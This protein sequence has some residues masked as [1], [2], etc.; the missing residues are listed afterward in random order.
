MIGKCT[1]EKNEIR[2]SKSTYTF[3]IF[4]L[5]Q[6]LNKIKLEKIN[7]I[8]N[9][10]GV[11][12]HKK[13]EVR[14]LTEDEKVILI[15]EFKYKSE[16]SYSKIRKI[17]CIPYD[18]IFNM[19][20][21]DF[22]NMKNYEDITYI[23]DKNEENV[24]SK[25][26]ELEAFHKLRKALDLYEK[27]YIFTLDE[28]SLDYICT[29][30]TL[31]KSNEKRIEYLSKIGLEP[32][33]IKLL[34][35]I[36]FFNFSHL[37]IKAIRKIIPYLKEGLTYDK[38]TNMVYGDFR[39][40]NNFE[41]K[42]KLSL[43]DLEE[44]TNPVVRRGISQ[45]I[46]VLN[47]I[48]RKYGSPEAV[49]IELARGFLKSRRER[50][51]LEK[52]TRN[53]LEQNQEIVS[54]IKRSIRRENI[55]DEEILK[56]KLWREQGGK[57][58]YS[59]LSISFDEIFTKNVS[60]DYIIPYSK[61]FYNSYNNKVLVK[62]K[63]Y[64]NKGDKIPLDFISSSG[65]SMEEFRSR[66]ISCYKNKRKINNLLK[67]DFTEV[68]E[69][70]WKERNL[71]DTQYITRIVLSLIRNH[72]YIE[73]NENIPESKKIIALRGGITYSIR[74]KLKIDKIR[75]SDRHHAIDAVIIAIAN[76]KII[77]KIIN[78]DKTNVSFLPYDNF[79]S[80]LNARI[81]ET[82]EEVQEALKSLNINNNAKAIFVSRMPNRK[83]KGLAHRET[84]NGITKDGNII[85]R[86]KLNELKLDKNNEIEGY[87]NKKDDK[88]LYNALKE[89]LIEANGDAK[90]AFNKPFFKPKSDGKN[91]P[92]VTK[93]KIE[94]KSSSNVKISKVGGVAG[95]GDT[96][97]I[98]VFY[99]K[100]E[101]YYF[102]PIYVSDTVKK[103]LPNRACITN[104]I[105]SEWKVVKDEDFIFS[106][107]PGD[108][109]YIKNKRGFN[110]VSMKK[111]FKKE[112]LFVNEIYGY[113]IKCGINSSSIALSTHD[114]MYWQPS[115]GI[116]GL[117]CIKK[118]EVDV[119]GNYSE[120]R[121]P[122]KRM[123]FNL[124]R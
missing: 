69:I 78:N 121:I 99:I 75:D 39:G 9:N 104:K 24:H 13:V 113:Y 123:K 86:K 85:V 48:V 62:S 70:E 29:I 77:Q 23:I 34:L 45:T 46:K 36:T 124:K 117:E 61:S 54:K 98:D 50:D 12:Y 68:D 73:S 4:K 114:R 59:G 42:K 33:V 35:K 65:K 107:Y 44:I 72:L 27:D 20:S 40:N 57:C 26:K 105:Q 94:Q 3:E 80:E 21:Y 119:L 56:Y 90:L 16:L 60:I 25:L 115:L 1:F 97:R 31:Y 66:V 52:N 55:T 122:E 100:N 95:N 8:K 120:V 87:Y 53:N 108:L 41:K 84:I 71:K 74:K 79:V 116:R 101:G 93:V 89:S 7:I 111:E 5:L 2:A 92:I 109:I 91:G 83:V 51:V 38:A 6:D 15:K 11:F 82:D 118:Y 28:K 110:M 14:G 49:N 102:V 96:V 64:K 32:E 17:L 18:Y 103:E 30:L 37:S 43:N 10:Y 88:L 22:V 58:I 19:I 81:K 67:E 47:A 76:E 106:L 63:E 112:K